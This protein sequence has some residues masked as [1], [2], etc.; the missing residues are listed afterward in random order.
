MTTSLSSDVPVGYFSWAKY[1]I[2]APVQ[3]KTEKALAAAFISNC[4]TRNFR[5]QALE[6]LEKADVKI[7]SYG[8]C[9]RN[10]DGNVMLA[11]L[12]EFTLRSNI[13][14]VIGPPNIQDFAPAPGSILPI[15]ELKDI[16]PVSKTMK[17]LAENPAAFN[18]S[19]RKME[20][21]WAFQFF[22][23]SCRYGCCSF[24]LSFMYLFL[25]Q[26]SVKKKKKF[27]HPNDLASVQE[28]QK[29]YITSIIWLMFLLF[30]AGHNRNPQTEALLQFLELPCLLDE[31]EQAQSPASSISRGAGACTM[32]PLASQ[33]LNL[34]RIILMAPIYGNSFCGLLDIK[35][36]KPF[37][38]LIDLIIGMLRGFGMAKI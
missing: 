8:G 38:M 22:Q 21:R 18:E 35:G 25:P 19:L 6:G 12:Q 7:D 11:K 5:L 9:H 34:L 26:K 1:N 10:C 32:A 17:Y 27:L 2:M 36:S 4:A 33:H 23:G 24:I 29:R 16:E 28:A 31:S 3:P 30:W 20:I 37:F 14:V 13:P 15:K